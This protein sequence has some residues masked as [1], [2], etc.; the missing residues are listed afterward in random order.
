SGSWRTAREIATGQPAAGTR[1]ADADQIEQMVAR[2]R[3]ELKANPDSAERWAL[4][5]R[6]ELVLKRY[7]ASAKAFAEANQRSANSNPDWLVAQGRAQGLVQGNNLQGAPARLFDAALKVAP[8][9]AQALWYAG[10]AAAE[11]GDTD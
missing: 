2:L 3:S 6:S 4:L 7:E 10:L 9:D 1:Q 5:G 11:A 8:D